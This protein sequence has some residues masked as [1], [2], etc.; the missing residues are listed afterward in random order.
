MGVTSPRSTNIS[1]TAKLA[2]MLDIFVDEAE[3]KAS[4]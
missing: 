3:A 4:L 1:R 2:D